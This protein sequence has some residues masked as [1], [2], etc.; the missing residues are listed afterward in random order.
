[1]TFWFWFGLKYF[2]YSYLSSSMVESGIE[3]T[4][5]EFY[6]LVNVNIIKLD[7]GMRNWDQVRHQYISSHLNSELRAFLTLTLRSI[8]SYWSDPSSTMIS[9]P[10]NKKIKYFGRDWYENS[11]RFC[12]FLW[13]NLNILASH[14][15][16]YLNSG[17]QFSS[18]YHT[19]KNHQ[20]RGTTIRFLHFH[21]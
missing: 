11:N 1:M 6:I 5:D 3:S 18:K 8:D 10:E 21:G 20:N 2:L 16:I 19:H 13:K 4:S 12:E 9:I 15:Y 7:D 17:F 14:C